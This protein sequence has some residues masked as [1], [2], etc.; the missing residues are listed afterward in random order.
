M[1]DDTNNKRRQLERLTAVFFDRVVFCLLRFLR[2][3]LYLQG[4]GI[5][6]LFVHG[7]GFLM[8]TI[9]DLFGRPKTKD[10][11]QGSVDIEVVKRTTNRCKSKNLIPSSV[12]KCF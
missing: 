5:S 4:L 12:I 10:I 9:L 3:L 11:A 6:L 2:S 7:C 1:M 8:K